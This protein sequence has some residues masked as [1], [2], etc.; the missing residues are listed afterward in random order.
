M[1]NLSK[2]QTCFM[3]GCFF[4]FCFCT[5][6]TQNSTERLEQDIASYEALLQQQQQEL[7]DID[8]ILG[9]NK[10][11]LD[12][13]IRERDRLSEALLTLRQEQS[14]ISAEKLAIEEE[15]STNETQLASLGRDLEALEQRL[16]TMLINLHKQRVGRYARIFGES[17]SLFELRLKNYYLSLLSAQ[18][19]D[20][21]QD[22]DTTV[23][24]I[25]QVQTELGFKLQQRQAVL[26]NLHRNQQELESTQTALESYVT[27]LQDTRNGQLAQRRAL[28]SEQ[29]ALEDSIFNSKVALDQERKRIAAEEEQARQRAESARQAAQREQYQQ[30]AT[31]ARARSEALR[32]PDVSPDSKFIS[33]FPNGLLVSAYGSEGAHINI[34]APQ[35]G[36]AVTSVMS[37]VVTTARLLSANSGYVVT[38]QH[39]SDLLSAYVN[40]Q[41]PAVEINQRVEQGD[42]LGYLGGGTLIP[43]DILQFRIA[44]IESSGRLIWVD[45]TQKLGILP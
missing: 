21:L 11:E 31:R 26:D 8:L 23:S 39:S 6:F 43:P 14:K 15:V 33:P 13:S 38:V 19:V 42:T 10:A 41:E 3:L 2:R 1:R 25:E 16:Q 17:E 20:L 37:G 45:P 28:L 44:T 4:F 7:N 40:L 5:V 30:Q 35:A 12:A 32:V 27:A 24:T 29:Q 9:T 34:R 36:T 18:D 22:L